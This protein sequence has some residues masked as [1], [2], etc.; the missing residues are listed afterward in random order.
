MLFEF[1]GMFAVCAVGI[2]FVLGGMLG[3]SM[4]ALVSGTI[5]FA[6][7]IILI[8]NKFVTDILVVPVQTFSMTLSIDNTTLISIALS[9]TIFV[10]SPRVLK[11]W[12]NRK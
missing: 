4:P 2:F 1:I 12:L 5:V 11:L 10:I 7:G 9:I 6:I 3:S 8:V